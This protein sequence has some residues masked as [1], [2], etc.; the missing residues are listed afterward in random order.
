MTMFFVV[1]GQIQTDLAKERKAEANVLRD[2]AIGL[3]EILNQQAADA[4]N[5][6]AKA[7]GMEMRLK[8]CQDSK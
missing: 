4:K 5:E 6:A 1:Y 3:T 7:A 2:Q 8:E